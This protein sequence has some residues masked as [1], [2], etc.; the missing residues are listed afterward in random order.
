[1]RR[2]FLNTAIWTMMGLR[3]FIARDAKA[4]SAADNFDPGANNLVLALATQTDGKIIVG[5]SFS[6]LGGGGTGTAERH[7]I[8]RLNLDGTIDGAFDPGANAA[9]QTL[10]V[11]PDGKILVGGSFTMIGGGAMGMTMRNRIARLNADGSVDMSFDPG[12]SGAVTA[13]ALQPDGK[14]LVAGSFTGLGGTTGT[15]TRNRIGRLN[16]DGSLDMTFDPGA[17]GGNV[18]ALLVQE[19]SRILVGGTFTGLGGGTGTMTTRNRIGRLN[20]NGTVDLG[21]DPGA[22]GQ[23]ISFAVNADGRIVVGGIFGMLGGG[24]TG[25]NTRNGIG[26]LNPNGTIDGSFNPG[27]NSSV[28]TL[29]VQADGKILVGGGFGMIGG[30]GTGM[31]TRNH[32]ARLNLDGSVDSSFNPGA[33][34]TV[35]SLIALP[36]GRILAGGVFTMMGGGGTG[37][38]TRNRIARLAGDG[39]LENTFNPGATNTVIALSMQT[40]GKLLVGGAFDNLA[41]TP[42]ADIGRLNSDG[43]IDPD[44]DPGAN[45]SVRALTVQPDSKILAGGTFTFIAGAGRTNI[46]RMTSAGALD[47][48]NPGLQN[49]VRTIVVQPDG[50]ILIGGIFAQV[51]GQMRQ[52]LARL[53]SAG[54]LDTSFNPGANGNVNALALQSDGKILVAG[55]FNMIGGGGTG[56]TARTAIARLDSA[57]NVDLSFDPGVDSGVNAV[58]VQP[59]GKIVIGGFFF[60]AGGGGSGNTPRMRLARLNADGTLDMTFDPGADGN[61]EALALQTDGKI[62]VAGAFFNLA[63]DSRSK[64]GRLNPDGTLD[65]S[66][67]P[68]ANTTVNGFAIQPDGK[69]V[70]AGTF[71][72]LGGQGRVRIGRLTN[73]IALQELMAGTN[74]TV[75]TWLRSG[76]SPELERATFELSTDGV[77]YNPLPNPIRLTNTSNWQS[78]GLNLPT[79]Q[80][81]FLRARGFYPSGEFGGS[82]S[83]VE[84]VR[85]AFISIPPNP[86]SIVSRKVHGATSFDIPLPL[87]GN[88]GIECRGGGATNDYQ[89]IFTFPNAVTFISAMVTGGTGSVSASNGSGTSTIAVNLAGVTNAQRVT[90]TLFGA[91][92]GATTANLSVQTAMLVGD[93]NGNGSVNASDVSQ[94]KSKSGQTVDAT[95]FRTDITANGSINASDVSLVKLRSGTALP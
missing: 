76:S 86:L 84:S 68:G 47:S 15:T 55:G 70:A 4:Q 53:D 59:D 32:I 8:G 77:S 85:N 62:L 58:V 33:N 88:P 10:A 38:F 5:G 79:Q 66:F 91:S 75:L 41:A 2:F 52:R 49:D 37:T 81:I 16:S 29:F 14:I 24:G 65:T 35:V 48:L 18:T 54:T 26:R 67:N 46:A 7:F 45:Q 72:T 56:N 61:V 44:F 51:A 89:L 6:M 43:S 1:M 63:G 34:N 90:V 25:T 57:G 21:F 11:Q 78:A 82:R 12:A 93:T 22:N 60:M 42:R 19:D 13:I 95:N 87:T 50:K 3:L 40:D 36:D 17:S 30:G 71:M 69:I 28:N 9:V 39:L 92:D 80:N 74:G 20:P 73:S 83:I 27:A 23:V 64:I 31:T 94:T